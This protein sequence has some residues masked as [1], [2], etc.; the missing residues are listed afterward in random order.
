MDS[1][2]LTVVDDI[3][4]DTRD[5]SEVFLSVP[6]TTPFGEETVPLGIN[7][8][9]G[10]KEIGGKDTEGEGQPPLRAQFAL[11]WQIRLLRFML[12]LE[13]R[14]VFLEA[15]YHAV[16]VLLCSHPD[17]TLLSQ[18]FQDKPDILKDFLYL[19]RTG[20]GSVGYVKGMVPI[21]LRQLS[22]LCLNAIVG[23]R[24]SANV[25]VMGGRFSWLQQDLGVNRGQYMG[26]LPCIL[27]SMTSFLLLDEGLAESVAAN[28]NPDNISA[29]SSSTAMEISTENCSSEDK[30]KE[31]EETL[32][33][34]ESVL[35]L[36]MALIA[37][38]TGIK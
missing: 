9:V 37:V 18:F 12:T 10:I 1:S 17:G 29:D 3:E 31:Y 8:P 7:T 11:I 4:I 15:L 21:Y 13:G 14:K 33:W 36:T 34:V 32:L 30:G 28:P 20:P 23:S 27:R 35:G 5:L 6:I 38:T 22:C 24:D 2:L 26:L 16:H 25:S 19:L